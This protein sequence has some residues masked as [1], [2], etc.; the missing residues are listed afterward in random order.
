MKPTD[1]N[2]RQ[3][4]RNS[5][6]TLGLGA[7]GSAPASLVSAAGFPAP[8][9][10]SSERPGLPLGFQLG[11]PSSDGLVVW[12]RA[13][14]TAQLIVEYSLDPDFRRPIRQVGPVATEGTD[15]T[16]RLLLRGAKAG[17]NYYVRA[18]FQ[19]ADQSRGQG[20]WLTGKFRLPSPFEHKP[21]RFLWS[22]D[23]CGQGWGINTEFGGAKIY[24]AMRLR[25][26]DFFIHSGDTVYADGPIAA[27][28][29][30]EN[31]RV[32]KN[33][34][35]EEVAKVAETLREFRGR[36]RYN[37][38]DENVRRLASEVPQIWQ[39]DDHEVLNNYSPSKDLSGRSEERRVGKE[40]RYTA[41][42]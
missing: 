4:L 6:L 41:T 15:F 22:G 19:S 40:L 32:W 25:N 20:P 38:L 1:Q 2:R 5:G 31:G 28:Q 42:E 24:E 3:F 8:A 9:L 13:D 27:E 33:I 21:I 11:D 37:L 7:L 35:T 23:M 12:A 17:Q 39:W 34:V 16:S 14:R 30:A 29:M 18:A 36:H 10:V 26:P